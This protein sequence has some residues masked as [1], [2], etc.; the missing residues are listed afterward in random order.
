MSY[1]SYVT[2]AYFHFFYLLLL[3]LVAGVVWCGG[4]SIL[5]IHV[6]VLS[7]YMYIITSS[8]LYIKE[9]FFF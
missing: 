8:L 9:T 6:H 7:L 1:V 5:L 4:R 3:Q 2:I